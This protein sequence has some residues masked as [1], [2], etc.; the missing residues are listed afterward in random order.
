MSR[1][2]DVDAVM[3]TVPVKWRARWCEAEQCACMGCVQ[4]GNRLIMVNRRADQ[5]DPE[6][7]DERQI[8]PAMYAKY[9]ITKEEW[10]DWMRR[11]ATAKE[12]QL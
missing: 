3:Q 7:I 2:D 6:R 10:A 8:P 4:V 1:A 9:K 12:K 11:D 5:I